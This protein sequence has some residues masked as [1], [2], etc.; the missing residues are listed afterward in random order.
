MSTT[1]H[2]TQPTQ[3]AS[4]TQPLTRDQ[5]VGSL[6]KSTGLSQADAD[7]AVSH[8]MSEL[9]FAQG[10]KLAADQNCNACGGSLTRSAQ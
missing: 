5:L 10:G 7:K 8:V 2:P 1:T 3:P 6:V 9:V 4:Q